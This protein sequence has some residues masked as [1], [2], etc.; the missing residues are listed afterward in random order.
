MLPF[1]FNGQFSYQR[2]GVLLTS[3]GGNEVHYF[4]FLCFVLSLIMM[5]SWVFFICL[6]CV[7]QLL[8]FFVGGAQAVTSLGNWSP[9]T[10]SLVSFSAKGQKLFLKLLS[11]TRLLAP[12]FH[13]SCP[14][15][16]PDISPMRSFLVVCPIWVPEV[17]TA[18]LF[19]GF[20]S[21]QS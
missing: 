4:V 2:V 19:P 13:I 6:M 17:L 8:S 5:N 18:T 3:N 14:V 9:F 21:G 11:D 15:L 16:E 1:P 7:S 12:T 10:L 20:S